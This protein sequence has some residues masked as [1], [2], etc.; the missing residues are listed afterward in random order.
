MIMVGILQPDLGLL[1]AILLI[2]G[3]ECLQIL[4]R[5]N[6]LAIVI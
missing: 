3:K 1:E 4:L 2:L 5:I 6:I